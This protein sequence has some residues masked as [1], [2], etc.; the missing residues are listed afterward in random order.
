MAIIMNK[1]M[2]ILQRMGI[3]LS[4]LIGWMKY[5]FLAQFKYLKGHWS[6]KEKNK[7]VG[8]WTF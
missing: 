6:Q 2:A 8:N 3:F 1:R 5:P 4:R 7:L